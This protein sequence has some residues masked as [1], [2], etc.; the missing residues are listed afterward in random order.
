MRNILAP[1]LLAIAIVA[2]ACSGGG[3]A[4]DPAPS[5]GAVYDP[6]ATGPYAVGI[7]TVPFQ[8]ASTA[9]GSPRVL[10]TVI[11]YPRAEGAP[12]SDPVR[13]AEA[14][15]DGASFPVVVYSHGS[16]GDPQFQTFLTEQLAS[17]G[18]IVAAPPHP[19]NT[20]QD[21]FPCGS[22]SILRSARERPA[23][24]TF[25]LDQVVAMRDDP[26]SLLG[27]VV[28]AE[29]TAIV[30]HSFGGWTAIYAAADGRFDAAVAQAP[31]Q[32]DLLVGRAAKITV[33]VMIIG[34]GKDEIVPPEGVRRLYDALTAAPAKEYVSLPEG[35]H[36]SFV[37]RCLGCTDALPPERGWELINRY[38]TA[39]LY[40]Y[41]KG[42]TRYAAFLEGA[43]PDAV[44]VP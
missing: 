3:G 15:G 11:W 18:F 41:V 17:H 38:T 19:G 27:R 9:D 8:R 44:V 31:G 28:D 22:E 4:M 5:P 40:V 6:A 25:V 7:T 10:E 16:G 35:R 21:C 42:D 32:P 33:P 24:V 23:D 43:P 29:R 30:G 12:G 2:A 37:D 14:A 36:L 13:D 26:A 1:A 39:W 34:S 20:F